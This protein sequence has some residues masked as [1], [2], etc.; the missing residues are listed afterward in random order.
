MTATLESQ[1]DRVQEMYSLHSGGQTLEE[2]G[3]SFGLT[4]QR[5][6][7][8]FQEASLPIVR[9]AAKPRKGARE[10]GKRI[11]RGALK[12]AARAAHGPF[13]ADTFEALR[14]RTGAPWPS[15][16]VI[17]R[18]IGEGSWPR[19]LEALGIESVKDNQRARLARRRALIADL[20]AGEL[21]YTQIADVLETTPGYVSVEVARMRKLGYQLAD[22]RRRRTS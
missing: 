14:R 6:S 7:Q 13:S 9:R 19:A 17:A 20:W 22:R 15:A 10:G 8:L 3:R 5:V 16:P 4:R 12:D 2:V 11:A 1:E 18:A 21:T